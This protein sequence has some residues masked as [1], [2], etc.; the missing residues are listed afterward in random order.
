MVTAQKNSISYIGEDSLPIRTLEILDKRLVSLSD[1]LDSDIVWVTCHA[2]RAK[3]PKKLDE[4]MHI[5]SMMTPPWVEFKRI[6]L[7]EYTIDNVVYELPPGQM[8]Y[9][10]PIPE[11]IHGCDGIYSDAGRLMA[12]M[13]GYNIYIL[14]DC[15]HSSNEEA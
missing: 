3:V 5:F 10:E 14:N 13:V 9:L 15:L 2:D 11:N 4:R 6:R 12:L 7:K 1:Y 8:D